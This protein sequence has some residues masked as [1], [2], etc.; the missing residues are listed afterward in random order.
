VTVFAPQYRLTIRA[1]KSQDPTEVTVLTPIAGAA[2]ADP[3]QITTQS[4]AVAGWKPYLGLI[5]GRRGRL[6]P[7]SKRTDVGQLTV[8]V[9][10]K[11]AGAPGDQLTRWMTAFLGSLAGVSRMIG[12]LAYLEEDLG[13]GT[14]FQAFFTRGLVKE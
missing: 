3:F 1:P 4:T 6:D 2:H 9:L 10:D 12:L 14:G 13:D 11:F 7:L 5:A 8:T